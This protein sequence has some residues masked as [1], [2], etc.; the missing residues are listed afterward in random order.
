[1][2]EKNNLSLKKELAGNIDC[3]K[4]SRLKN[5]TDRLSKSE[6]GK[7]LLSFLDDND[8]KINLEKKR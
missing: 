1:M 2:S 3:P 5:I 8:Y 7:E 4:S 6:M